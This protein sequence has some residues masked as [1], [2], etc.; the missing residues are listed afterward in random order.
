M[1]GKR[2][3][4]LIVTLL[5]VFPVAWGIGFQSRAEA[6]ELK[7]AVITALSGAG[8]EWGRGIMR[9]AELAIEEVNAKGGVSIGGEKY[10]IVTV[11][12]DDK[13]TAAGG[14]AAA[15]K[16][17][18]DDKVKFIIGP[19][20]SA[21]G[22][23][24]QDITEKNKVIIMGDTWAREFLGPQ[25][26]YTFRVFM[27]STEAAPGMA[28]WVKKAFPNANAVIPVASNDASG[29][30][31]SKDYVEA[32]EKVG[33]KIITKEFP[34][35]V[36]KDYYP[37]L[38]RIKGKDPDIIQECAMG[39]GA[40]ALL[41]KQRKELGIRAPVIGGAWVDPDQFV[42]SAGGPEFA[43]GYTYPVV[44]DRNSKDPVILDFIKKF[45]KKYGE[46]EPMETVDPSF[47]S[48]TKLFIAALEK[49]GSTDPDKVKEA[50]ES[51]QEF[52]G[53]LGKMRWTGKATYGIDHQIQQTPYI[54]QIKNGKE[55]IIGRMEE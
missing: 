5:L 36:T 29:W 32:Y 48:G 50:L 15:H 52:E 42:R 26:P 16:A 54:A 1:E 21:S 47:Y 44:F 13:Y 10:K 45:K 33:M 43:E 35:R 55:V 37:I 9:G 6:K 23:A 51:I 4:T 22:L 17:V 46:K 3:W 27:T 38:T 40:A 19:I 18:F 34:E 41:T 24:M 25:K 20:S 31:I 53:L 30:S 28:R 12:Y 7:I 49:A 11:V 8:A 14:T 2:G 39:V